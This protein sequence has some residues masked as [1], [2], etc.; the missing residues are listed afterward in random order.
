MNEAELIKHAADL[1]A[2]T[3]P[4]YQGKKLSYGIA[5]GRVEILGNHTDYNEGFVLSAAID[6]YT[7][8]LGTPIETTEVRIVSD[9]MHSEVRFEIDD[10]Q[11][12][13]DDSPVIWAN[14]PKG[15]ILELKPF[16]GFAAVVV[17]TVPVGAGVSSSAALELATAF[18]IKDAFPPN[19]VDQDL[20]AL[21]IALACKKSENEFVG[22]GCG[23]LDQMTCALGMEDHLMIID[24]RDVKKPVEYLRLP[25]NVEFM[26]IDSEAPHQLV[27]GKY[28]ELRSKCFAAAEW[29]GF[30]FLRDVSVDLF[31][32]LRNDMPEDLRR[33]ASHIIHENERVERARTYLTDN[34]DMKAFGKMLSDSHNSS[35]YDFGNSCTEIDI[36]IDCAQSAPGFYGGRIQGGGFGGSTINLVN[37]SMAEMFRDLVTRAY[38]EKTGV[39]ATSFVVKPSHGAR[40]GSL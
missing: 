38:F 32:S 8:M 10:K 33:V 34:P 26:V 13:P 25:P 15:V 35:R 40:G 17:S 21:E 1:F 9:R 30:P 27:A 39:S 20:N 16:T 22:V 24:C 23:I 36:L 37:A 18:F 4:E 2:Q 14:Y 12:I 6:R 29:F 3:F 7:V 11:R 28:N 31:D 5:P 19:N